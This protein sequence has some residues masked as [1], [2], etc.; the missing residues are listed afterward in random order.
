MSM[1]E[2]VL[3]T[4][5]EEDEGILK[6]SREQSQHTPTVLLEG[7]DLLLLRVARKLLTGKSQMSPTQHLY[8]NL[9]PVAQNLL[10]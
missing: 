7:L 10:S 1:Q 9:Q 8:D 3:V 6:S 4:R 5:A 2:R